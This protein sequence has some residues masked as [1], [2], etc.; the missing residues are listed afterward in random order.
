MREGFRIID[1]D[2]HQMEPG[3]IWSDY[4][5]AAHKSRAPG[6]QRIGERNEMAVEGEPVRQQ[7]GRYA[8]T[9]TYYD[10]LVEAR[11]RFDKASKQGFSARARLA[12]MDLVGVDVQILNPTVGGQILGREYQDNEL[13]AAICRAYND[14]SAE[15]CE[16]DADRL[17]WIAMLPTQDPERSVAEMHRANAMGATAF[18]F[19]P[20]PSKGRNLYHPDYDPIFELAQELGKPISVH[21]T[22][23]PRLP[24]FADRMET[25]TTGH[26]IAHPF[27]TMVTMMSLI[28]YGVFERFPELTVV[29]VEGDSG[30]LPYWLQR[31]EQHWDFCGNSE[32]PYLTMR[33][34]EYFKRNVYVAARG[35][36]TTLPAV[37]SA[38]GD[39]NLIF[40]T[41]YP[42]SDG[43]FPW[44]VESLLDQPIADESKR[45]ILYDNAARAFRLPDYV[46]IHRGA[47]R[48]G[49]E[50][51]RDA[52]RSLGRS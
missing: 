32:H 3:S 23:S 30:W 6:P 50:R 1:A 14:W 51:V 41:D 38:V 44:G 9:Q 43:S 2:C 22:G 25:H 18:Y 19:R 39:D 28:W 24:S 17:R 11:R 15:Y 26:I 52:A 12:D 8:F 34:T 20:N 48:R 16:A 31:M 37:V 47:L 45:K 27:E 40:N 7:E 49:L 10:M 46:P 36:E 4:I 21:D 13:L 33:P 42:H 35:D 5:D 29:L